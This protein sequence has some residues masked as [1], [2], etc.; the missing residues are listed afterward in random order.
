MSSNQA[1][2]FRIDANIVHNHGKKKG[3]CNQNI[4]STLKKRQFVQTVPFAKH[5][6]S[7]LQSQSFNIW[8]STN[9]KRDSSSANDTFAIG[10]K[11]FMPK[12]L[13][14]ETHI[15]IYHEAKG[16]SLKVFT[17]LQYQNMLQSN[18]KLDKKHFIE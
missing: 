2:R 17:H 1:S 18:K 9:T 10:R 11:P 13:Q 15:A 3:D 16:K 14:S 5:Y 8:M 6:W 4:W 12:L 7:E